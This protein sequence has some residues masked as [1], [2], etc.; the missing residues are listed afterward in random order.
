MSTPVPHVV[1]NWGH[2]VEI[3][4]GPAEFLAA[5]ERVLQETPSRRSARLREQDRLVRFGSW[6]AVVDRMWRYVLR[7]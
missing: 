5:V 6:D 4:D 2:V 1:T 3:A 7:S